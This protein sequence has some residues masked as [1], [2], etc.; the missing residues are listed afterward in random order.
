MR[1]SPRPHQIRRRTLERYGH[2]RQR[3]ERQVLPLL[4]PLP[5]FHGYAQPLRRFGLG[6]AAQAPKLG[7][8][9]SYLANELVRVDAGHVRSVAALALP[10]EP[11][12]MMV[13][14]RSKVPTSRAGSGQEYC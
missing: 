14:D 2:A 7:N 6:E 1:G 5:V 11:S 9:P 12:Y 3:V 13:R 10:L 4:N 8:T